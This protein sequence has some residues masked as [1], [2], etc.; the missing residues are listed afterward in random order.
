MTIK[1]FK[2]KKAIKNSLIFTHKKVYFWKA[3]LSLAIQHSIILYIYIYSTCA[4]ENL[5]WL[6]LAIQHSKFIYWFVIYDF[7][8]HRFFNNFFYLFRIHFLFLSCFAFLLMFLSILYERKW[9]GS[10]K[11]GDFLLFSLCTA[12]MLQI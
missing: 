7:I 12:S 9:L 2:N 4:I 10:V 1:F 11:H 6:S 5:T 3:W 8:L